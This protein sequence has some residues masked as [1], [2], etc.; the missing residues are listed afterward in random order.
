MA[1]SSRQVLQTYSEICGFCVIKY[2]EFQKKSMRRTSEVLAKS[3]E[4]VFDELPKPFSSRNINNNFSVP[5]FLDSEPLLEQSK[6][7]NNQGMKV[8]RVFKSHY[9]REI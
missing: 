4:I 5:L 7:I 3:L 1:N 8:N 9:K 2:K 6:E